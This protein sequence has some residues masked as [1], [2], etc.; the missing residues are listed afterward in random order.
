MNTDVTE[1]LSTAGCGAD[2]EKQRPKRRGSVSSPGKPGKGS[3]PGK[4]GIDGKMI[5]GTRRG[6][7]SDLWKA[8]IRHE[9]DS[10]GTE[11]GDSPMGANKPTIPGSWASL[12]MPEK[13]VQGMRGD[14][15]FG[16][17]LDVLKK[18]RRVSISDDSVQ[19]GIR[20]ALIDTEFE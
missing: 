6:T 14:G 17:Y 11:S 5:H 9:F 19:Y 18:S 1:K 4:A 15:L 3:T 16:E 7:D 8:K 20:G 2:T 12:Q 13:H 10:S